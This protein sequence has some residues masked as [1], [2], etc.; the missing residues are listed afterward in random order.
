VKVG[1]KYEPKCF[2]CVVK[3]NTRQ[4]EREMRKQQYKCNGERRKKERKV[5]EGNRE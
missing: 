1:K 5:D 3:I 4:R 2:E